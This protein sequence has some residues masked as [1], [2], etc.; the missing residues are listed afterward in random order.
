MNLQ[1]LKKKKLPDTSGV[2]MFIGARKKI[3]YIGKAT[4]LRS[5][6]RSYFDKDI[7]DKRGQ[8]IAAMVEQA[9]EVD[10][11]ETDSVLEALILEANLIKKYEPHYNTKEKDDKS[12]NYIVITKEDFPRVL[13][14]RARELFGSST[15]KNKYEVKYA[16]GPFPQGTVLKDA[17]KIIRKIFPFRDKCLPARHAQTGIP[18]SGKPC[19]N[20]QIKLCPG[21]CSGEI[22][23]KEYAKVVQNIRLFLDGKKGQIIKKLE[24]E[25]RA[26]AKKLEFEKAS[27]IKKTIFALKHIRDVA[28]MKNERHPMS[29]VGEFRIEAYDVAHI[30]G[31]F[32]VGVMTVVE[33]GEAKK[34]DYRKFKI[35]SFEGAD[36]TRALKEILE[37]RLTHPQW[38]LPKLMVV[39]GGKA[40]KNTAEKVLKELGS[41]IPVVGVVKDE[42]HKPK[43]ITG[44]RVL[45]EKYEKE[46]LLANNEAHRFAITYHRLLRSKLN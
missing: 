35:K 44:K 28:L 14:V 43:N 1:D 32:V 29:L 4:S 33:D 39:D 15:P 18:I 26:V 38:Q 42:R 13:I 22:S 36:D 46:I 8:H 25:M 37:R 34:S 5:R 11:I 16:F 31:K 27:E 2:Y 19:F 30:S 17:L 20:R 24:R 7:R 9:K 41:A 23:K 40:Q 45:V 10:F 6:V 21:V 3:L 12:F